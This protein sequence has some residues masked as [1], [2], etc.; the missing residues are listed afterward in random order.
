MRLL[1]MTMISVI[2]ISCGQTKEIRTY[3]RASK[4]L[5]KLVQKFP[6]LKKVDSIPYETIVTIPPIYVDTTF[7]LEADTVYSDTGS[8]ITIL[9]PRTFTYEKDGVRVDLNRITDRLYNMSVIVNI[10][11]VTL[12]D[13]ILVDVIQPKEFVE[14]PIKGIKKFML[15]SGWVIWILVLLAIV[16]L[17]LKVF[18]KISIPFLMLLLL[19]GCTKF[20]TDVEKNYII[21][22]GNHQIENK[23]IVKVK[24][25][26]LLFHFTFNDN[27]R[28]LHEIPDD[29]NRLDYNKLF[30]LTSPK[31]HENSARIG[32]RELTNEN[33][34]IAAYW[35]LDGVRGFEYLYEA[36]EGELLEMEVTNFRDYRFYCNGEQIIIPAKEFKSYLA[37]PYIGGQNYAYHDMKFKIK[38]M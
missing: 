12:K 10:P 4:K 34:E 15:T 25:N 7:G 21:K 17:A 19:L 29:E 24:S 28:Y 20:E 8:V 18:G 35:Y 31:I 30:G 13:T 27:H 22:T 26:H 11:P 32:W 3:N 2:L 38:I 6:E 14:V 33:F 1:I 36:K 5:E 9:P 16:I 23:K 37:Y